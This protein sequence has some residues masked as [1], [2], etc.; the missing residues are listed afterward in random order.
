MEPEDWEKFK[1]FSRDDLRSA[2]DVFDSLM[3]FIRKNGRDEL[4]GVL[5]EKRGEIES[6]VQRNPFEYVREILGDRA[7]VCTH[8]LNSIKQIYS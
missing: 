3:D 5:E 1:T 6:V 8:I 4:A 2:S 7:G